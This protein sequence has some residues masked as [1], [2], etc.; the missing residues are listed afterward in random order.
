MSV[1]VI[2]SDVSLASGQCRWSSHGQLYEEF[3][4]AVSVV[5]RIL[6]AFSWEWMVV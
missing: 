5:C 6:G 2:Q 3:V 4:I 1:Y